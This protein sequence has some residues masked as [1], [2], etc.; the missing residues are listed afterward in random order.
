[1]LV[2]LVAGL[3]RGSTGGHL[4]RAALEGIA[5]QVDDVVRSMRED[6]GFG[7]DGN[8]GGRWGV[9]VGSVDSIS[10]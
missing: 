3:T 5:F 10:E 1:M 7:G 6:T 2:G 9:G 8:A 4:A